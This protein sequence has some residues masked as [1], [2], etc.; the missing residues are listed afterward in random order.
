MTSLARRSAL[1]A[2]ALA[3]L[4]SRPAEGK[5]RVAGKAEALPREPAA[6]GQTGG[7]VVLTTPSS[8]QVLIR[9]GELEMG[10]LPEEGLAAVNLC[11]RDAKDGCELPMLREAHLLGQP[12]TLEGYTVVERPRHQVSL[13]P[14]WIDRR[15][16]SVADYMRCVDVGS[17]NAPPFDKGAARFAKPELPVSYVSWLDAQ[18]YCRFRNGRLPTEAE[19]ERAARGLNGRRFPWGNAFHPKRANHGAAV[20]TRE[21]I[22][23]VM[24]PVLASRE[25]ARD[26]FSELAPVGSFPD[27]RTPEG[28]EDLAGNVA[29]WVE[30]A[31][32][33]EYDPVSAHNPKGPPAAAS[34]FRVV[35][36]GSYIDPPPFLRGAARMMAPP[37]FRAA[38]IGF[39]CVRDG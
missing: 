35:R 23:G 27:G 24:T 19:F 22:Q 32:G 39:R 4:A 37:D 7:V 9:G 2:L 38:F 36:G 6:S 8:P 5:K 28:V 21:I 25:D 13:S 11:R 20:V 29:E 26:G 16:V 15:E 34:P 30:D 14:F 18:A 12:L 31:F 17:C 10:T 3:A 1:L 33:P